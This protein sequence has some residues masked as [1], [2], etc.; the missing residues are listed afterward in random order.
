[1]LSGYFR[2]LLNWLSGKVLLS[3]RNLS[4]RLLLGHGKSNP[5]TYQTLKET[6]DYSLRNP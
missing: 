4:G 3:A 6:V 1:M 2:V 5:T